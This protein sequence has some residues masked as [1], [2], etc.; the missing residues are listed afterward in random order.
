MCGILNDSNELFYRTETGHSFPGSSDLL[1]SP[2][3][4]HL[5]PAWGTKVPTSHITQPETK[6]KETHRHRQQT[7]G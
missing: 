5:I 6:Q 2:P 1:L 3:G 4:L 7:Y